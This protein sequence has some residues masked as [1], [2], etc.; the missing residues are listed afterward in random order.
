MTCHRKIYLEGKT[1]SQ[2][3][4]DRLLDIEHGNILAQEFTL[5]INE[6]LVQLF[7]LFLISTNICC[8]LII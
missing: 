3:N 1:I 2:I 7:Y 8:L 5:N 4:Q 6:L